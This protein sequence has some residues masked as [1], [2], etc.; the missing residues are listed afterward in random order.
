V[1]GAKA[2]PRRSEGGEGIRGYE[3]M[4]FEKDGNTIY[5]MTID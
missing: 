1:R 4:L 3:K 2:F 5:K